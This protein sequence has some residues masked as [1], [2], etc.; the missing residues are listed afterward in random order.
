M[1]IFQEGNPQNIAQVLA[2][3]DYRVALQQAI[4]KKYPDVTLV[5]INLNIPGPIKNNRYLIKL[6]DYGIKQLEEIWQNKGY[7]YKLVKALNNDAGCENFYVLRESSKV[8]K[9]STI[10]FEENNKIGRLFDA[11]VLI[12]GK[13]ALSRQELEYSSRRCYLC[14]RPAKE[15]ARSRRHS[16]E[17]M[18]RY[19]SSLYAKYVKN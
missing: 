19:I 3:K 11:D 9:L 7:D 12:K 10:L 17:E 14:N 16:V 6:F 5:D 4:F 18:Q 15:C 8:V 1:N 13:T 2:G